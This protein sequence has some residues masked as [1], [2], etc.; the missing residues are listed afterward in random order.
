[1][2]TDWFWGRRALQIAGSVSLAS[3]PAGQFHVNK[4]IWVREEAS[5]FC[6]EMMVGQLGDVLWT[7]IGLVLELKKT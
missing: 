1:M 2:S 7:G 3:W 5:L 4:D 6:L